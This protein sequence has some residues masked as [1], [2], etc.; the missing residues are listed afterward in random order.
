MF[1]GKLRNCQ[2]S[3]RCTALK[4]PK[5]LFS[6]EPMMCGVLRI[7]AQ[8]AKLNVCRERPVSVAQN[9]SLLVLVCVRLTDMVCVL[10]T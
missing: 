6:G 8:D 1:V 5:G 7:S 10:W 3:I 2:G 9:V 4:S